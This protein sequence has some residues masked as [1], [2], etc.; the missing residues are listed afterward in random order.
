MKVTSIL[1]ACGVWGRDITYQ[2]II[3]ASSLPQKSGTDCSAHLKAALWEKALSTTVNPT[4]KKFAA[5]EQPVFSALCWEFQ[6][7]WFQ[8]QIQTKDIPGP[9]RKFRTTTTTKE[10]KEKSIGYQ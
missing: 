2:H 10:T 3:S 4:T 9:L 8:V 6:L 1:F 5:L 7:I